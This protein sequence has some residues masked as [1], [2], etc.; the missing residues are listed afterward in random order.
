M[1]VLEKVSYIITPKS[2][3]PVLTGML[4]KQIDN[5]VHFVGTDSFRLV[6]YTAIADLGDFKAIV[7]VDALKAIAPILKYAISIGATKI[8]L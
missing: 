7:P 6:R 4:I 5:L 1:D 8:M 3:S 2:F